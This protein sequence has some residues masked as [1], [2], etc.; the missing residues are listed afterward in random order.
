MAE[1]AEWH[2]FSIA[3]E[4]PHTCSVVAALRALALGLGAPLPPMKL[5]R[6]LRGEGVGASIPSGSWSVT[7]DSL[8]LAILVCSALQAAKLAVSEEHHWDVKL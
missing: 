3:N 2:A 5:G 6:K 4:S 7:R 8:V 1:T